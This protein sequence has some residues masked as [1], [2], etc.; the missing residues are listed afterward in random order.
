MHCTTG[1]VTA[2]RCVR[3]TRTRNRQRHENIPPCEDAKRNCPRMHLGLLS[4]DLELKCVISAFHTEESVVI[5]L[6][7]EIHGSG[8]VVDGVGD[9][10]N[11]LEEL[12]LPETKKCHIATH[13]SL[14]I[15][16]PFAEGPLEP[17]L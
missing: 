3:G 10:N 6:D 12:K 5:T 1:N 13:P 11:R 4:P 9:K 8:E 7:S 14:I 17:R 15:T 16:L 2:W